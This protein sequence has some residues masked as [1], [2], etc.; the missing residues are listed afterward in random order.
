MWTQSINSSYKSSLY[1]SINQLFLQI[2]LKINLWFVLR[3][4]MIKNFFCKVLFTFKLTVTS[5]W[6]SIWLSHSY[7]AII[8][9]VDDIFWL[10]A[11][12]KFW[13][14]FL[15]LLWCVN[16]VPLDFLLIMNMRV[17]ICM[18]SFFCDTCL[19]RNFKIENQ[20]L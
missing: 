18:V 7:K 10:L 9:R 12:C 19:Y 3:I 14:I 15:C 4:C 11:I 8:S 5:F 16:L 20:G 1:H 6:L 17:V 13:F 2:F